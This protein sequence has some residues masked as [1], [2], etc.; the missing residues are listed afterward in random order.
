M[1]CKNR[2]AEDYAALSVFAK[3]GLIELYFFTKNYALNACLFEINIVPLQVKNK[4]FFMALLTKYNRFYF[5]GIGGIG[6]SALARY[7]K[8]K[9]YYVAGY[10]RTPSQLTQELERDGIDIS[11]NDVPSS[12]PETFTIPS[13]TLVIRTPA[14]PEES[15]ILMYFREANFKICKRAEILG[16]ICNAGRSLCVAGTHGKTTTSTILAHL[17]YQSEI[18][19]NAFLG[20]VS[21]NYNSNL[22]VNADTNNIVVEADEYDHSFL[23]LRPYM[24]IVTAIDPD[25]L[26]IYG[27]RAGFQKGFEDFMSLIQPGGVLLIKKGIEHNAKL[28]KDVK[29][30]TYAVDDNSADF[31]ADNIVIS[32]GQ[33]HFDFHTPTDSVQNLRLGVP[34]LVNIENSVAAMSVAWLNGVTMHE[35]RSG[36]SSFSGVY[37]RFNVLV[38]N[39]SVIY[40]D[41]YAH[42]PTE[43]AQTIKSVRALY[44]D[45][46]VVGIFQPHLYT[47]TRDFADG[48]AS[49]LSKL[50]E[51]IL[52]P[53]YPARELPIEG[54]DSRMILDRLTCKKKHLY[55]KSEL[56]E[57]LGDYNN[58]VMITLGA[59]DI[60][61]LVPKIANFFNN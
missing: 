30:Y 9:G 18:G 12:I 4:R 56:L 5:L 41:D 7:F 6:M 33:I 20:G 60:D 27:D 58:T 51:V 44:P 16:E 17:L 46:H 10:D 1:R 59:G 22:L 26:D 11:Y 61:R 24:A 14:V 38:A 8:S 2:I 53:I 23:Q 55:E 25:H 50:D 28:A 43:I 15:T 45:K 34:V 35:I 32:N 40:I 37:R 13:H 36:L 3:A 31:Y 19:C 39:D 42:H 49:E 29:S 48:F 54:V 21:L 52:L 57:H 47:R